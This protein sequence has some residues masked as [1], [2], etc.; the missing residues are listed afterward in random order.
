MLQTQSQRIAAHLREGITSG[1]Y[2]PGASLSLRTIAAVMRTSIIPV[3]DALARLQQ[4]GLV[5][6]SPGRGWRVQEMGEDHLEDLAVLREA[7][8]CQVARLC[9]E[10]ATDDEL[11]ELMLLARQADR[12]GSQAQSEAAEQRFHLRLAAVARSR[13]LQAAIERTQVLQLAFGPARPETERGRLHARIVAAIA[14]RDGD[15]A[16]RE[17]RRHLTR[18][19]I[20]TARG[21]GAT[22]EPARARSPALEEQRKDMT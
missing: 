15:R 12:A 19:S 22:A 3:R 2:S 6:G 7:L 16:D 17:M 1:T 4:E 11:E 9:S 10:R 8:E 20:R 18:R 14:R 21:G 5:D 13:E